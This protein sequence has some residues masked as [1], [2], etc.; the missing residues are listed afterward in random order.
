MN[1]KFECPFIF[2]GKQYFFVLVY[3]LGRLYDRSYGLRSR[4]IRR[5]RLLTAPLEV[6][7]IIKDIKKIASKK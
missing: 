1:G 7:I 3:Y 4:F 2:V 6:K 5:S